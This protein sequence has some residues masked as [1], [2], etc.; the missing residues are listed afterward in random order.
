MIKKLFLGVV[1]FFVV[2]DLVIFFLSYFH[3]SKFVELFPQY[4]SSD[5]R[6]PRLVGSFFLL[7]AIAR[8]HGVFNA[9]E[10]G[11]YRVSLWSCIVGK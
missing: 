3:L 6:Y 2:L 9:T 10:K 1:S 8:F 4:G 11:A 5:E 7:C